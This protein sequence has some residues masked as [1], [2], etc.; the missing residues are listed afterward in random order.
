MLALRR[1]SGSTTRVRATQ[2]TFPDTEQ[3]VFGVDAPAAAEPEGQRVGHRHRRDDGQHHD[4][5]RFTPAR[6]AAEW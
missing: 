6:H 5:G 3:P 1:P 2:A 4:E